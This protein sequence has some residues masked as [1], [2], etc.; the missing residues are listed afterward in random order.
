MIIN[1]LL[2]KKKLFFAI[3]SQLQK[4]DFTR[5]T[6]AFC[7]C[8]FSPAVQD[9]LPSLPLTQCDSHSVPP[10]SPYHSNPSFFAKNNKKRIHFNSSLVKSTKKKFI[11]T[12]I[13]SVWKADIKN[14]S[15]VF[16]LSSVANDKKIGPIL[17]LITTII[18][19]HVWIS[20]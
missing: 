7:Q 15:G 13:V 19:N 4:V 5:V 20:S 12:T 14:I 9:I 10:H 3:I 8:V 17:S 6:N 2:K 1:Y 16:I 11:I 18:S